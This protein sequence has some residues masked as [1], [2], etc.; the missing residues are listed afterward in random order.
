MLTIIEKPPFYEVRTGVE[1]DLK[2]L[3]GRKVRLNVWRFPPYRFV[4]QMLKRTFGEQNVTVSLL[5]QSSAMMPILPEK[6][7]SKLWDYQ[8]DLLEFLYTSPHRGALINLDPGMGKTFSS[9]VASTFFPGRVLVIAPLTFLGGWESEFHDLDPYVDYSIQVLHKTGLTSE[10]AEVTITNYDTVVNHLKSFCSVSWETV[11]I[12]ESVGVKNRKAKR[13]KAFKELLKH[14]NRVWLLSGSP[15]TKFADDLWAQ[16]NLID[17]RTFS[18]YWR[19]V[20]QY[21]ITTKTPWGT[22][23]VGNKTGI[24]FR[25]EFADVI[26]T[27][28]EHEHFSHI[29]PDYQ[30]IEV[31]L[32]PRQR[33]AFDTFKKEFIVQLETTT[34]QAVEQIASLTKLQQIV[35]APQNL[36]EGWSECPGK[37]DVLAKML[38]TQIK[39]PVIVW[40]WF[41]KTNDLIASHLSKLNMTVVQIGG[42]SSGKLDANERARIVNEFQQ[43]IIEVL[44]VSISMGKYGLTLSRANSVVF[45]DR[46]WDADAHIQA[47]ARVT[48]G[49]RGVS[50]EEPY[51]LYMLHSPRTTDDLVLKNLEKKAFSIA[52][53]SQADLIGLLKGFR[54]E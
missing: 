52:S 36:D 46:T 31:P 50:R 1:I 54:G 28:K 12:D 45:Y 25:Q 47:L 43:G 29:E 41:R 51:Q 20:E 33:E 16:L 19:F 48:G 30:L 2:S 15:I 18:S 11:I 5:D 34:V 44:V 9:V 6:I 17:P 7:F 3:G 39:K 49:L 27:A 53:V 14:A 32:A 26:Y 22:N 10:Y 4:I 24:D 23:I 21:C 40:T 42:T 35:S 37:L 13:T 8:K 38:Q